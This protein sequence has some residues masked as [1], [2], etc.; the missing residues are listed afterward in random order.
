MGLDELKYGARPDGT[1]GQAGGDSVQH[2]PQGP[3]VM[4]NLIAMSLKKAIASLNHGPSKE[5]NAHMENRS[6]SVLQNN[7]INVVRDSF[8]PL[9]TLIGQSPGMQSSFANQGSFQPSNMVASGRQ[10]VQ[11]NRSPWQ[12]MPRS[13]TAH[14]H[15]C[16]PRPTDTIIPPSY[17]PMPPD[18]NP[19][20]AVQQQGVLPGEYQQGGN[21]QQEQMLSS[22][23]FLLDSMNMYQ[24]A[25]GRMNRAIGEL[26]NLLPRLGP[27]MELL[28]P[29]LQGCNAIT[30]SQLPNMSK[31]ATRLW[32]MGKMINMH[33]MAMLLRLASNSH[34][35]IKNKPSLNR[36]QGSDGGRQKRIRA[37][38]ASRH[39]GRSCA[40]CKTESTPFWRRDQGTDQYLCNA[41]G[42]YYAKNHER[43]PLDFKKNKVT[44]SQQ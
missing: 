29:G 21:T 18:A 20:H 40:H 7:D 34:A 10:N 2:N 44:K 12:N 43:R 24:D 37:L 13:D 31:Q 22:M 15:G 38:E 23:Q 27:S 3:D 6:G 32:W 39:K 25:M 30:L 14:N 42:L 16:L 11:N 9:D 41:C 35:N 8:K 4:S 19:W 33:E 17:M 28:V 1:E 5:S 36:N 26:G